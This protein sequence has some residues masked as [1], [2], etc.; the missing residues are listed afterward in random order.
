M[1]NDINIIIFSRNR[2]MQLDLLLR[3]L[4]KSF[5]E[6]KTAKVSVV[7]DFSDIEYF[8]AYEI[9]KE[10]HPEVHFV[11][12]TDGGTFKT[13][14][15]NLI[16]TKKQ[17]TMFLCDDNI[18]VNQWSINDIPIQEVN[19]SNE[20]IACSLRLWDGIDTCYATRQL[21][22]RPKYIN[23][24][25][26]YWN[27]ANGDWGYPMSVDGNVY[28]TEFILG[29]IQFV[30]FSNPNTLEAGLASLSNTYAHKPMISF[31]KDK[32]K[33]INVPANVV[34]TIYANRHFNSMTTMDLN[35][36][37]LND[38]RISL[39]PIYGKGF[40]TVHVELEFDIRGKN[41]T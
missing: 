41:D 31:F 40:N 30:N 8:D 34:Q 24:Y 19:F 11:T 6:I 16:D 7:Y 5:K 28:K 25:T 13:T 14:L 10:D 17:L 29:Q 3:S 22:P 37:F 1:N 15:L 38:K 4:K 12:D 36:Y 35:Q 39:T 33:V 18:F 9:L 23:D 26:F 20:I 21:S 32:P 2:A 27:G